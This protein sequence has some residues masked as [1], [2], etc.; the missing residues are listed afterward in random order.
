[1][2]VRKLSV[3]TTGA[4]IDWFR[5]G[6]SFGKAGSAAYTIALFTVEL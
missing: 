6:L 3:L 1:M 4:V 2:K 5:I